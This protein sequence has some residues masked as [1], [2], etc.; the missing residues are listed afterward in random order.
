VVKILD[1]DSFGNLTTDTNPSFDL[2]IGFAG[3]L[4]DTATGLVRFGF[5]DY[6]PA[7][8]RWTAR[9]PL[10]FAGGQANLYLYA[11]NNPINRR[12]PNGLDGG[13]GEVE[14]TII[15]LIGAAGA[16][17]FSGS[18]D[19]LVPGAGSL[20]E[21]RVAIDDYLD[22]GEVLIDAYKGA[23]GIEV[24]NFPHGLFATKIAEFWADIIKDLFKRLADCLASI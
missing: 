16:D 20:L 23:R 1:G 9:D 24:V 13:L 6:D 12:D 18:L 8:G 3:G 11:G 17:K 5:R 22:Y 15:D 2:P 4:A 10:L 7:A 19:E 21:W 14:G